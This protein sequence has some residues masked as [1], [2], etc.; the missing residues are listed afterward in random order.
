M[1]KMMF[2]VAGLQPGQSPTQAADSTTCP[3]HSTSLESTPE[4]GQPVVDNYIW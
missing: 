1:A 2:G 3:G 4:Q